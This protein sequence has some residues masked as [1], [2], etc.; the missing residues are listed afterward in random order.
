MLYEFAMTPDVFDTSVVGSDQALSV[1]LVELLRGIADN[2]L[3][4]NL[5]KDRWARHVKEDRIERLSQSLKDKIIACLND[6]HDRNRVVRHPRRMAGDPANDSEW[7]DLALESHKRV[8]F[9]GIVLSQA[10]M[11]ACGHNA[12]AFMELSGALDS[13]QWL[14]RQRS[15]TLKKY[16]ADYRATFAPILRCARA[17]TLVDPYLNNH[18][19]RWFDTIRICS[20]LMGQRGYS[21]LQGRIYIHAEKKH[22]ESR[23]DR[24]DLSLK[25]YLDA[26]E[27]KLRPLKRRDGHRF[28]VFLWESLS[29]TPH[30]RFV[31][32]DQCGVGVPG[33]LDCRSKSDANSTT[34]FLLDEKDRKIWLDRVTPETSPYRFLCSREVL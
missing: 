11:V 32:T 30:D 7:L 16:E 9:Y 34:W 18:E 1:I 5:H 13:P 22:Q 10:L 28:K 4:A 27:E 19:P 21:P 3:L 26:W 20:E 2:G 33:G 8:P 24:Y 31:L 29:E 15:L 25:D 17:L 12:S 14:S 6:L 23:Y